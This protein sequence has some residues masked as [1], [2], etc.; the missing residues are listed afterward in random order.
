MDPNTPLLS[1]HQA[2]PPLTQLPLPYPIKHDALTKHTTPKYISPPLPF[3]EEQAPLSKYP[4]SKCAQPLLPHFKYT[5]P[6]PGNVICY[7]DGTQLAFSI[8]NTL[9]WNW[10]MLPTL[11]HVDLVCNVWVQLLFYFVYSTLS[12]CACYPVDNMRTL[13]SFS[14]FSDSNTLLC[15]WN[16]YRHWLLLEC[17]GSMSAML[18]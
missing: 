18:L 1:P 15:A 3:L 14:L 8:S 10:D 16:L 12:K 7:W 2:L 11:Q 9:Q 4:P 6:S 13:I 17:V 5:F